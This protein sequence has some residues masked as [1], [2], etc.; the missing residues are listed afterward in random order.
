MIRFDILLFRL[1]GHGIRAATSIGIELEV[2]E[3]GE[4]AFGGFLLAVDA[5]R[6]GDR[7]CLGR[8]GGRDRVREWL[9]KRG[10]HHLKSD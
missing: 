7:S 10:R 5:V 1:D 9:I 2:G 4:R 8:R 3:V 6:G